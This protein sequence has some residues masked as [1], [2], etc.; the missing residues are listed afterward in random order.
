[1]SD[2][3]D[4][5]QPR[6][7]V[8]VRGVPGSGRTTLALQHA[9]SSGIVLS[10]D[11]FFLTDGE[12]DFDGSRIHEAHA[13]NHKRAVSHLKYQRTQRIVIDNNNSQAW[14]MREYA[15]VGIQNGYQVRIRTV[16]TPWRYDASECAKR[17]AKGLSEDDI[18]RIIKKFDKGDIS[19]DDC[20][21]AKRPVRA[22]RIFS[23]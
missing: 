22:K 5:T 4:G 3:E 11:D 23:K 9:G 21:N 7:L 10:T 8:L 15:H 19:L 20:L 1:M 17:T 16:D 2:L 18:A 6:V 14:E 13:W 12:Y